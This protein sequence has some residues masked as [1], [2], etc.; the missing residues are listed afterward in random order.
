M[1]DVYVVMLNL[2]DEDDHFVVDHIDVNNDLLYYYYHYPVSLHPDVDV[3][4]YFH[5]FHSFYEIHCYQKHVDDLQQPNANAVVYVI[6]N[7]FY[8]YISIKKRK[9]KFTTDKRNDYTIKPRPFTGR[10]LESIFFDGR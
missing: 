1:T 10:P 6:S 7:D 9:Q 4:D 2:F 5:Y 8:R 3:F